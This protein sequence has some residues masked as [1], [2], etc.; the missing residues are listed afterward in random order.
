[1]FPY[2]ENWLLISTFHYYR[3]LRS[4]ATFVSGSDI[5]WDKRIHRVKEFHFC[6]LLYSNLFS[7]FGEFKK[8]REI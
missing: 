3:H 6:V 8:Y 7:V 1:M 2:H 4:T 5:T